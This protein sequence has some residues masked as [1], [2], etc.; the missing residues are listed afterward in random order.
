MTGVQTCALPISKLGLLIVRGHV[1]EGLSKASD[2][3]LD[4]T[5]T[6]TMGQP[7]LK[8]IVILR[9]GFLERDALAIAAAL[10]VG[11]KHPL[12]LSILRAGELQNVTPIKLSEPVN[13]LLGKGLSSGSY[14]LGS[15]DWL[16]LQQGATNSSDGQYGQVY[17]T[18]EQGVI[19]NFVFLD[20]P[21]PGLE[22]LLQAVKRKKIGRAHV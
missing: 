13:N 16:G 11:Q 4:K 21:R 3:V 14:R 18:D 19:A 12:A 10:E 9:T 1:L 8:E 15:A 20:T 5:G 17:L 2:L 7:E 6:L 22:N